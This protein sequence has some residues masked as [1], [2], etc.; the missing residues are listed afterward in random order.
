[1]EFN[2]NYTNEYKKAYIIKDTELSA[3]VNREAKRRIIL[4]AS[5]M[6]VFIFLFFL[7][8]YSYG[9]HGIIMPPFASLTIVIVIFIYLLSFNQIRNIAQKTTFY[10][11][12]QKVE[13]KIATSE[14][15]L[16]NQFA[17]ARAKTRYG[18]KLNHSFPIHQIESTVIKPNEI[19]IKS[20]DYNLFNGNGK[21]IIPKEIDGFSMV[22][23]FILEHAEKFK[24]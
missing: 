21:I 4:I 12:D 8:T 6:S 5:L 20:Y 22:K 19:I 9:V 1:M 2:P 17:Q 3:Y 11:S 14:L 15:N 13:Q 23:K 7:F 18:M 16:V 10:I 24:L